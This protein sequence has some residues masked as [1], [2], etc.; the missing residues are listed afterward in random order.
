VANYID[1]CILMPLLLY[2]TCRSDVAYF[3]G[4]SETILSVA[5]VKP[6]PGLLYEFFDMVQQPNCMC[7]YGGL[8]VCYCQLNSYCL[9]EFIKRATVLHGCIVDMHR[10]IFY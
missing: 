9:L 4:L 2:V 5:L 7:L 10:Y 8:I 6:K 1:R 3:D